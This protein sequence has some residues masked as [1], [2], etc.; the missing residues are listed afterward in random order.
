MPRKWIPRP[1]AAGPL[2]AGGAEPA[3]GT[4][5]RGIGWSKADGVSGT[6]DDRYALYLDL[7]Y[8]DGTELWGQVAGF[9]TGTHD[10]QREEVVV[11]PEKPIKSVDFDLLLREHAGKAWFREPILRSVQAVAGNVLFDGVR[12]VPRG[13]AAEGFQVRDVAVG[14]DFVRIA[15]ET[16][17]LHLDVQQTRRESAMYFD[18]SI[19]DTAGKDRAVTL[20][21]GIPV[22]HSGVRWLADPRHSSRG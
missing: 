12:V 22:P 21:Y 15:S 10:W 19:R 14:S 6:I 5:H 3:N 1:R 11:F 8:N 13:P 4:A 16:L 2:A 9:H 18:V 7:V 17:G 20:L